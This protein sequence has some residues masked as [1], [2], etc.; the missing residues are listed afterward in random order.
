MALLLFDMFFVSVSISHRHRRRKGCAAR[1][2]LFYPLVHLVTLGHQKLRTKA[3][4]TQNTPKAQKVIVV[5]VVALFII[6]VNS[7]FIIL[8]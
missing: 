8:L 3:T 4:L 2:G 6:V 1:R 7:L 5:V